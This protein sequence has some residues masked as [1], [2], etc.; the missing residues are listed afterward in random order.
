MP[1]PLLLKNGWGI[2]WSWMVL[3]R[4]TRPFR[5]NTPKRCP[6]HYRGLECKSRKSRDTQN[7]RQGG[8]WI[9]KWRA[10]ANRVLSGEHAGHRKHPF[11]TVQEMTLHM[12]ITRWWFRLK[13]N[14]VGKATR[15]FR[16]DLN[17]IP[18]DY[19]VEVMK[20]FKG[21]NLV[22]TEPEELCTEVCNNL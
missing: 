13:L 1:Q 8:P 18:Y 4:P 17:E 9:T 22:D 11:P 12:D 2:S 20:R 7:N 21:L 14:K 10:K 19:I 6:F 5:T 16:Y 15:P 3:W